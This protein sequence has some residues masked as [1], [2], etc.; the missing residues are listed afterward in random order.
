MGLTSDTNRQAQGNFT[1]YGYSAENLHSV[2][3]ISPQVRQAILEGK[4]VN[5]AALL[6]PYYSGPAAYETT[7]AKDTKT[8]PRLNRYLDISEFTEAFCL[9]RSVMCSVFE[10]YEELDIYLKD[11][12]S[13][14]RQYEGNGFYEYHLQFSKNAAAYVRHKNCPIDW[15]KKDNSLYVS[16]FTS[17]QAT[18][19]ELCNSTRHSTGFCHVH[20]ENAQKK[21]YYMPRNTTETQ[22]VP[23]INYDRANKPGHTDTHGR[24]INYH[25][26]RAICNN[27]NS[28]NGC[29]STRCTNLH[30]CSNCKKQHARSSCPQA[31]NFQI[32]KHKTR[33]M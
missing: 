6:I 5:L 27:Y 11:I 20:L 24:Q 26:N 12:L 9:Y 25:L 31:K 10:R 16:I 3:T 21:Q 29:V 30:V 8:D 32:H 23:K 22:S 14:A 28:E 17:R 33:F 15:A 18:L 13:M 4:D 19:C 7:Y 2:D 1:K